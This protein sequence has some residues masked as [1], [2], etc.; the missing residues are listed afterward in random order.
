MKSKK[1]YPESETD[2]FVD[3]GGPYD[4]GPDD[5]F[6]DECDF[7]GYDVEDIFEEGDSSSENDYNNN[8][9]D[10]LLSYK[11][12][13][14]QRSSTKKVSSQNYDA[15][16]IHSTK[17]D[18]AMPYDCMDTD[19]YFN[20]DL[21]NSACEVIKGTTLEKYE[22]G[23]HIPIKDVV[24]CFVRLADKW[25]DD[26]VY[27][28]TLIAYYGKVLRYKSL[29]DAIPTSYRDKMIKQLSRSGA[30]MIKSLYKSE[31]TVVDIF[32]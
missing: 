20:E 12:Y 7:E 29:L 31:A 5:R 15:A 18:I 9:T 21:E 11:D 26:L 19:S 6:A 8:D 25:P 10:K 1:I 27:C 28:F 14:T 3:S 13:A 23:R 2:I 4:V 24:T 22:D 30:E 16:D 32:C 17:Q